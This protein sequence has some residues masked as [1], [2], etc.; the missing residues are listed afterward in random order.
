MP[1]GATEQSQTITPPQ[2]SARF[3]GQSVVRREDPRFLAGHGRYVDDVVLPGMLHAAFVRSPVARGRIVEI[4][5]TAAR[6]LEGVVAVFTATDLEVPEERTP[7]GLGLAASASPYRPLAVGDVRFVGDPVAIVIASSRYVAEDACDLVD[8]VLD[9]MPAVLDLELAT[10]DDSPLVHPELGTNVATAIT[11]TPDPELDEIFGAAT[12]VVTSTFR[13]CRATNA[14]METRGLIA[15]W[16]TYNRDMCLWSAT[17]VPHGLRAYCAQLLGVSENRVRVMATDVGGGFGQKIRPYRDEA[18]VMLAGHRLGRPV[19]WIEDRHENLTAS[20]QAREEYATVSM[21]L[22]ADGLIQGMRVTFVEEVGAF[23]L[24][25]TGAMGQFVG[26]MM[27]GPYKVPKASFT[28]RAVYTNRCGKA[29]YRGPWLMETVA[30]EQMM[31]HVARE[32]GLDPL[33]L[34]RRNV[35]RDAD[36]PYTTATGMVYD[37]M[38]T[39]ESLEQAAEMLDYPAF[40]AEQARARESGRLL[41]VGLSL[42]VEP[43]GAAPMGPMSSEQATIRIEPDGRVNVLMGTASTGNSVETTMVQIVADH[44]G[45]AI[46]DV[47]L[48][49]GDTA[50]SPVGNGTGGSRY[51]PVFGGAARQASLDLR[52]KVLEIAAHT[53]E[54]AVEDL[55]M[56]NSVISVRGIPARGVP[57][58]QIAATAYTNPAALPPGMTAELEATARFRPST[59]FTWSNACHVC[60]CEVDP[61]TGAVTL[62]R[63]IVSEDCGPMINPMVV[64]GQIDG[65]VVQGIAGVLLEHMVYDEHGNPL[66]TT[67]LDYLLPTAADVPMIEHGH[68]QTSAPS[69]G[70]G[71]KGMGEG[72]AIGAPAAV[73]NAIADALAPLGVSVTDF[74]LGPSEV[75]ALIRAADG[76]GGAAPE[77]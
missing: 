55:E 50:V 58:A 30:R 62:L 42:Y 70:G 57:L 28:A 36:L 18:A 22:D 76:D 60:T 47:V 59:T 65:G 17:Q 73:A 40:R 37:Q 56:A 23:P 38:T 41:G 9:P 34:R 10:T 49:H 67:F 74:P 8:L 14:P 27:P 53:M 46:E 24:S 3:V 68:I 66:T 77:R 4:D 61:L 45:C 63:F 6:E 20:N 11:P 48:Q 29:P 5:T 43:S 13:Q 26:A 25:T 75:F 71:Y 19:K 12:H 32:I 16:D 54:A 35:V 69:G 33:E 39:A 64:E 52:E 7:A 15:Q 2:G 21:A 31:D 1:T 44:L 51:G 72:G